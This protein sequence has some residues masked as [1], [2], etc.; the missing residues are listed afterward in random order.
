MGITQAYRL[1]KN[2]ETDSDPCPPA[3]VFFST[4][5][6]AERILNAARSEGQNRNFKEN[7]PE[8]YS[9]AHNELIRVGIYLKESQGLTYRLRFEGHILQLQIKNPMSHQYPVVTA[10]EPA[11]VVNNM[12]EISSKIDLSCI[13]KPPEE[14]K[15]KLTLKLGDI[16]I[17]IGDG[18][19]KVLDEMLETMSQNEAKAIKDAFEAEIKRK[20]GNKIIVTCKTRKDAL[21]L[22]KW[23]GIQEKGTY[24]LNPLPE[25]FIILT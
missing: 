6:M 7:I 1:G 14:N 4:K 12:E 19:V 17:N 11:P 25:C 5:E 18:P 21:L 20:P 16:K 10:H 8:A 23:K 15:R 2:P 3:M 24:S 9:T 22:A 13:S